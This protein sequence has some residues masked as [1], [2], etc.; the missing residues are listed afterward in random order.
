MGIESIAI[1]TIIIGV[2]V[3]IVL[4]MLTRRLM[5]LMV[6]LAL[7]GVL[8]LVLAVGGLVW[9]YGSSGRGAASPPQKEQSPTRRANSR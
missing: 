1:T 5:R 4:F 2:A 9:W 3:T 6:R 8:L 7:A